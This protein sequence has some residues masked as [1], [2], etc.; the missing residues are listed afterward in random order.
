MINDIGGRDH[1]SPFHIGTI[2]GEP[3][4]DVNAVE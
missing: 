2:A 3:L 4:R 1:P